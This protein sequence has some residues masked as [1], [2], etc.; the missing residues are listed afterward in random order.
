MKNEFSTFDIIKALGIPRERLKDWM[1]NFFIKATTPADGQGTKA[2]FKKVDIYMIELFRDLL[3]K[4]FKRDRAS[5][6]IKKISEKLKQ[7]KVEELAYI[8]FKYFPEDEQ[9]ISAEMVF[10]PIK[11][12]DKID[13]IWGGRTPDPQL[14]VELE[15]M[16]KSGYFS[17]AKRKEHMF[18]PSQ[19]WEH[20]HLVNFKI[21]RKKVD[22]ALSTLD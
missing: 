10:E 22:M 19:N 1:S 13:L 14:L 5:D 2:I 3:R 21:L 16:K 15:N 8:I 4:G 7:E 9:A 12:E 11:E 6:F 20:I 17:K 18:L